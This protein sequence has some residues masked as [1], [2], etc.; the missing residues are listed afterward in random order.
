MKVFLKIILV[1]SVLISACG[2]KLSDPPVIVSMNLVQDSIIKEEGAVLQLAY[3]ISDD[4]GLNKFRLTILDDFPDA[5]FA[6]A[7]WFF[8]QDY[9][10]SG[11]E[12]SDTVT[13]ELPYPDLEVGQYKLSFTIADI[14]ENEN[15]QDKTFIIY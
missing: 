10:V 8:E 14:D 11:T 3:S 9:D 6:L 4:N 2:E 12:N 1:L 5:R 13:I 15:V 7:P